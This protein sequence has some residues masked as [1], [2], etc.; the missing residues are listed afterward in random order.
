DRDTIQNN[1]FYNNAYEIRMNNYG[2]H[3]VSNNTLVTGF[4]GRTGIYI[5]DT[6][7]SVFENNIMIGYRYGIDN[8]SENSYGNNTTRNNLIYPENGGTAISN[9]TG[10]VPLNGSCGT[11]GNIC[12]QD[13]ILLNQT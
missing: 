10:T 9:G 6:Y 4:K 11:N 8:E 1:V 5:N 2:Q 7:N 3:K 12:G 13:P